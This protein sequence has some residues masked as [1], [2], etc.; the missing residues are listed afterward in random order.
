MYLAMSLGEFGILATQHTTVIDFQHE[1]V[2]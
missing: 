1:K 2:I